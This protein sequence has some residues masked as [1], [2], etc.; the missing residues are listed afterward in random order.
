MKYDFLSK[1]KAIF[2][3]RDGVLNRA[4]IRKGKP[5]PPR[6]IS[7][8]E[9]LAGVPT[10]LKQLKSA[11]FLLIT[12]SNQPDVARGKLSREIV[13]AINAFLGAQ[14]P[15]DHFVMCYHDSGDSCDCRK[16]NPGMIIR[17][18]SEF[19]IDLGKSYMIGD[20]WRDMAAG[21][22]AGCKTVFLDYKYDEQQPESF[23]Y[24]TESLLE[25]A[26]IILS[27]ESRFEAC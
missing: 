14:L 25:A 7:E 19:N 6:D 17:S 18:A 9:I 2:L 27:E 4:L 21:S 26:E 8:V 1:N 13:D 15:I 16:P 11:G 12:I 5:Y 22:A 23:D 10:A 20:R 24:I 3:D